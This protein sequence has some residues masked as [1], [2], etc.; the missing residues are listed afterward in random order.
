MPLLLLGVDAVE[1]REDQTTFRAVLR[2]LDADP[3]QNRS[4]RERAIDPGP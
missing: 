4:C 2:V 1:A 3:R